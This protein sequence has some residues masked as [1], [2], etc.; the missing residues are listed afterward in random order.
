MPKKIIIDDDVSIELPDKLK[1]LKAKKL[2]K[3]PPPS[4]GRLVSNF[5]IY[6]PDDPDKEL[7]EFDQEFNIQVQYTHADEIRAQKAGEQLQIHY[8]AG[9]G[10]KPLATQ[11]QP[12]STGQGGIGIAMVSKWDPMVAW[13]P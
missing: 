10:W 8:D 9:K 6:D 7:K 12:N 4:K 5:M 11:L 3:G 2:K 1:H 13:F